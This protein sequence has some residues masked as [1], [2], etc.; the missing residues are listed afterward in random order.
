MKIGVKRYIEKVWLPEDWQKR[1]EE[2]NTDTINDLY[3]E[4]GA[5]AILSKINVRKYENI[6]NV[7]WEMKAVDDYAMVIAIVTY[8]PERKFL[9]KI[10]N[11]KKL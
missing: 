2:S 8:I 4:E 9:T 11:G 6:V 1:L 10:I 7:Q 3:W 5:T